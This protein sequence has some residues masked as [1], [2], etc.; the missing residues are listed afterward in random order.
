VVGVDEQV[1]WNDHGHG[2]WLAALGELE[3]LADRLGDFG[4]ILDFDDSFGHLLQ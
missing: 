3:G 4:G 2:S 1:V